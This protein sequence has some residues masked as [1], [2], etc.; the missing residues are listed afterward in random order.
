MT[1]T[2]TQDSPAV[3]A[4]ML[5][6]MLILLTERAISRLPPENQAAAW[7]AFRKQILDDREDALAMR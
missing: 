3:R 1:S 6:E 4:A 5:D 2:T 7:N